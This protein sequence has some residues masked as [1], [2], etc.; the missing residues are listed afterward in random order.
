MN[1]TLFYKNIK[2]LV[3]QTVKFFLEELKAENLEHISLLRNSD[4]GTTKGLAFSLDVTRLSYIGLSLQYT[5]SIAEG[6]GSS[7]ASSQTSVFRNLNGE[8]PKV[9]HL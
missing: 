5:Y 3:N 2:G 1:V 6:T 4:F 7:T 8:A 9:I